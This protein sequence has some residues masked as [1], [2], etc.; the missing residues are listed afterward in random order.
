MGCDIHLRLTKYDDKENVYKELVLYKPG[1]SYHYED[2]KKVIDNPDF[3]KVYI[4]D[5][6]RNS[7]M[8]DG[9]KDGD[10]VDGYGIFPI[11]PI[12]INSL[13]KELRADIEKKQNSEGYFDFY[14][15][16]PNLI[17]IIRITS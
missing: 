1:E 10:E 2:G 6:C 7:E 17:F 12:K 11:S 16:N 15:I 13:E 5:G 3:Q 4:F 14:E 8:F 9:M